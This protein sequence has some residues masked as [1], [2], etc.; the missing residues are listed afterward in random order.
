[1][2]EH[3]VY[4]YATRSG[5]AVYVG[6]GRQARSAM[7][8]PEVGHSAF[9]R[10]LARSPHEIRLAGPYRDA[11]EAKAVKAAF[12]CSLALVFNR[13]PGN[14]PQFVPLGVPLD[15]AHRSSRPDDAPADRLSSTRC[16]SRLPRFR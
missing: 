10:W 13:A 6:Y 9:K 11:R 3:Y 5:R 14:G 2:P 15:L 7:A 1:M 12:I 4:T 16:A 8:R